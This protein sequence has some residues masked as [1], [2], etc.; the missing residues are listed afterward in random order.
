M[1]VT[2]K[3]PAIQVD[4]WPDEPR[5]LPLDP[6]INL[7]ERIRFERIEIVDI[8]ALVLKDRNPRKHP[9]HQIARLAEVIEQLGF[10]VPIAVDERGRILAGEGRYLAAKK[11]GMPHLPVVRLKHL[12]SAQKRAFS[13]A[14]NRLAELGE[15]DFEVL[16]EELSFIFSED[17]QITFDPLLRSPQT[18]LRGRHQ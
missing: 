14:D 18:L 15:W 7:D 10:N 13:I 1:P 6:R 11:I 4:D 3:K 9:E 8:D 5:Q 12:T 17:E 2:F 16:T